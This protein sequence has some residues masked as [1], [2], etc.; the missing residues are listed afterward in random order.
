MD[1][2]QWQDLNKESG[3]EEGKTDDILSAEWAAEVCA[4]VWGEING[5]VEELSRVLQGGWRRNTR[6]GREPADGVAGRR[7]QLL[8]ELELVVKEQPCF[9]IKE[10]RSD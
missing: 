7:Q 1:Y 4:K 9:A 8:R 2:F 5:G 10:P 3:K 6:S